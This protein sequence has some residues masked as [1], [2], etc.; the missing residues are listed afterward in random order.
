MLAV[1]RMVTVDGR[2]GLLLDD[3]VWDLEQIS[4][5]AIPSD[6]LVVLSVY[7][8]E[9]RRLHQQG[10]TGAGVPLAD[11]RLGPP[12]PRPPTIFGIGLNYR[13]HAEET[14]GKVTWPPAVFAKYPTA[15]TGPYDDVILPASEQTADWEAEL[16]FVIGRG[17]RY[18][19]AEHAYDHLAGFCA[20]QDISERRLQYAAGR[21]FCLGKS[22]DTFC[23]LGP[24]L[25]TLDELDD[26]ADLPI[27][28]QVNGELMQSDTTAGLIVDV[29]HLV[30]LLSSIVTLR[31]G[32][33]CITGTPSG[34]GHARTPPLHLKPGD[35]IETEIVGIGQLR[36]RCV[37]ESP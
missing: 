33:V 24:A 28:C 18:I 30:E 13:K 34:V 14:G 35:L 36:N 32:D 15:V 5:G 12:V 25:V 27:S 10:T 23:P 11:V 17:G 31:P 7:W 3:E 1:M 22:F 20:A 26:P 16:A 9:V 37:A 2:A 6:P 19:K 4:G 29:P 8:D 21:Q